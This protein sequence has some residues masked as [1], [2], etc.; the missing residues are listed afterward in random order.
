M[1]DKHTPG[2]WDFDD[3]F[4][5]ALD[6]AGKHPDIYIA[7]IVTEDEEGRFAGNFQFLFKPQS[8]DISDNT[9]AAIAE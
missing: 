9:L 3:G 2:D 7:E 8:G 1:S 5:V 4:I 6:P